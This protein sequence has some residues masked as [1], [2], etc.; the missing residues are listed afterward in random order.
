[1][2]FAKNF[3]LSWIVVTIN[4]SFLAERDSPPD[5]DS[6]LWNEGNRGE[7]G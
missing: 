4:W 1:M 3:S 2:G 5:V 6:V 7:Q